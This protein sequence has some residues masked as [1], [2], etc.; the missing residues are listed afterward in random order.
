MKK[1][2]LMKRTRLPLLACSVAVTV[3]LSSACNA[4]EEPPTPPLPEVVTVVDTPMVDCKII[5]STDPN[6]RDSRTITHLNFQCSRQTIARPYVFTENNPYF[7]V[8]LPLRDWT[9]SPNTLPDN[10]LE[11]LEGGH[12]SFYLNEQ[13][14]QTVHQALPNGLPARFQDYRFTTA[15]SF[16]NHKIFKDSFAIVTYY[17]AL[18]GSD[19]EA[20]PPHQIHLE[21]MLQVINH[22]GEV[23]YQYQSPEYA[24]TDPYLDTDR[25]LL[26]FKRSG[27]QNGYLLNGYEVHQLGANTILHQLDFDPK[28]IASRS[29]HTV[30]N[31]T[32]IPLK[33][34]TPGYL[35]RKLL[36]FDP[37]VNGFFEKTFPPNYDYDF[38]WA[39]SNFVVL[40]KSIYRDGI[41]GQHEFFDT[42]YINE[43]TR[44]RN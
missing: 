33:D 29:M 20:K 44:Y 42:V 24:L 12:I 16:C 27:Y 38:V 17:L 1:T 15:G 28:Y 5:A 21:G 41:Q 4:P 19:N 6:L 18:H 39:D 13:N 36:L 30:E 9:N 34:R 43:F 35:L 25:S 23:I 40:H 7:S 26:T 31:P 10:Y 14:Y 22:L 11:W 3:I 32:I 37:E 2:T 8:Q